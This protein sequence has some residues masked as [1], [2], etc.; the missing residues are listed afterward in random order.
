MIVSVLVEVPAAQPPLPAAVIVIVTLPASVSA[1]LGVYVA[2]VNEFAFENVPVPFEVQV[3][4][5]VFVAL[6]PVVIFTA[7]VFE[8]VLIAVETAV[9]AELIVSNLVEVTV[10]QP[11]FPVAVN[12]K[13]TLPAVVS[14]ALGLY[15]AV[16][17]E[18]APVKV[19]VPLLVHKTPELLVE[20]EPPVIFT[21][22]DVEHVP[23]AVPAF[24]V[25]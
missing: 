15:L 5:D 8:Q 3:I 11:P 23:T 22:P 10:A 16:V 2:V 6:E 4:P 17:K 7:P 12:V 9:A 18:V 20:L 14:A 19:P 24:T 13:V 1:G 21:A 25:A